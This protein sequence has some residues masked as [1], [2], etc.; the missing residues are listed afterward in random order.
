VYAAVVAA[1]LGALLLF[2]TLPEL[3]LVTTLIYQGF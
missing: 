2:A 3:A 1:A